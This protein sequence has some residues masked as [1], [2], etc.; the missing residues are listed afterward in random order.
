M[1]PPTHRVASGLAI[2]LG[3]LTFALFAPAVRYGFTDVDDVLYTLE[4]PPVAGGLSTVHVRWA[5]TTVHES[6]Y[7]PLTWISLMADSSLFGPRPFGY[8]LTNVWLH[9]ANA[10]LLAW[11]LYRLLGHPLAAFLAAALWAFH[12]L[13][14]ES[15]VWIA[16]RKDVLSGLFFLLAVGAHLRWAEHPTRSR[17]WAVFWCMLCGMLSKTILVVLPPL[18]LLLDVWP[19]GRIPF[20]SSVRDLRRWRPLLLEKLP[21][22]VLMLAGILL[23][24]ITH[25]HAHDVAPPLPVVARLGLIAPTY[26]AH[27]AQIL[28][29]AHLALFYPI[30][31]PS[32]AQGLAALVALALGLWVAWRLRNVLPGL[33]VGGLWFA[34]ALFPLIRGIRFDEQSAYPDRYTYLPAIGLSLAFAGLF[35]A[36]SARSRRRLWSAALLSVL[37]LSACAVRGAFY[38]PQWQSPAVLGPILIRLVPDNPLVNNMYGKLLAAQL[39]P[40]EA[41]PHFRKAER[42]NIVASCNLVS[43]LLHAGQA[44]EALPIA[45][46]ICANPKAPPEAFLALGV[47]YLQLDQAALAIPPLQRAAQL[48]PGHPLVWQMLYRAY[49]ESGDGPAAE[50]CIQQLRRMN[51]LGVTDFDGLVGL[52]TRTWMEGN[53]RLAWPFFDNNFA[54][55]PDHILLRN[56]A[57]W[58]L[59]TTE[60]PP[61]PPAEAVHLAQTTLAMAGE[62]HPELLDTLAAA[63]A[64]NG[65]FEAAIHA[66]EQALARL[67]PADPLHA[68]IQSRLAL[69]RRQLPF[70]EPVRPGLGPAR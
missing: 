24:L 14:V 64:A 12:P 9:A 52:Y 31:Y 69:Y 57:A 51:A 53:S 17:Q 20:P 40:D 36:C 22:F 16:E 43:A 37:L 5:F 33:L 27:L 68:K 34:I 54:R 32:A 2:L 3:L 65:D 63:H 50:A 59:A 42:W 18:L 7:S 70:R 67:D 58:L 41:I 23:T 26:L 39:K 61:A 11:L 35:I 55:H 48:M 6:W 60:N 62:G 19:L 44:E 29:P 13:R 8:H 46:E 28:W 47:C 38:L 49:L 4:T 45:T 25:R 10:A 1:A 15:V 30:S 66:A 21:L 56:N